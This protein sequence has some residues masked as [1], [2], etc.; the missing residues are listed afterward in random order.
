MKLFKATA[1]AAFAAAAGVITLQSSALSSTYDAICGG[2]GCSI[3]VTAESIN[4]PGVNIPTS[5]VTS[6]SMGGDSKTSVGTGVATTI[7]F[8]PIGLLGFLA[9]NES[10]HVSISGYDKDGDKT[11]ISFQFKNSK[12][13]KRIASQLPSVTGLAMNETRSKQEILTAEAMGEGAGDSLN[14][15]TAAK[16]D[17][18]SLFAQA[19][20]ARNCWTTYL[21]G[22]PNMKI[23][24]D[25]NPGAAAQNKKRFDDC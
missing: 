5:R 16:P 19:K 6:W 22:N 18:G 10:Y 15:G 2:V 24:A 4:A 23:W 8:G 21:D 13:A 3:S 17:S 14:S 11:S 9:K 25:A 1:S 12:P 20:P 7:V